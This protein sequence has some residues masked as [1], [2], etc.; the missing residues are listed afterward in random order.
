[1]KRNMIALIIYMVILAVLANI[2]LFSN[3]Y[4]SG[5]LLIVWMF[6][7]PLLVIQKA[8]KMLRTAL[9]IIS[10][11]IYLSLTYDFNQEVIGTLILYLSPFVSYILTKHKT[12]LTYGVIVVHALYIVS[13][14]LFEV[15]FLQMSKIF[16]MGMIY[17]LL[18]PTHVWTSAKHVYLN[19]FNK[20]KA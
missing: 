10:F 19:K 17:A 4:L 5:I 9:P 12:P 6:L 3:D 15:P 18:F 7:T 1:M 13:I 14:N 11:F 16:V 20:K 8:F 2:L